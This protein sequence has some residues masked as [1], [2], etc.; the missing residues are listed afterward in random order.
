MSTSTNGWVVLTSSRTT[1]RLPRLRKWIIPGTHR[2]LLIRDGS[3]GFPLAH[4]ALWFHEEVERLDLGVWDEWGYAYR[5]VRGSTS[6][7]CHA[8]GTAVDLNATR[9]PM[10][11]AASAT[12]TPAQI[13]AIRH[14]LAFYGGKITWGGNWTTRPD[15]MHF[16]LSDGTTLSG[17]ERLAH[18]L[19]DTPRGKRILAANPGARAIINS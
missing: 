18:R 9:H 14:R 2:H 10:G 5:P 3:A 8:S 12:F 7:S 16:Q 4:L 17:M 1:G 6:W 15:S 13:R 19:E 11:R